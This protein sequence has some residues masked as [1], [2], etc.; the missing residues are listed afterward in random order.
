MAHIPV[1]ATF[2]LSGLSVIIALAILTALDPG[3]ILTILKNLIMEV[4]R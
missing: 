4:R 1:L 2:I 3:L